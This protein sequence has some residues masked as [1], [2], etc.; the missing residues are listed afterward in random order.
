F[1]TLQYPPLWEVEYSEPITRFDNPT[2][3]FTVKPGLGSVVTV[4]VLNDQEGMDEDVGDLAF[5]LFAN[6][7][8]RNNPGVSV[9]ASDSD[10]YQIDGNT[11]FALL[12]SGSYGAFTND[13]TSSI[14]D[15]DM[16]SL[17]L[18]SYFG[19]SALR[20]QFV[21]PAA[22]F[23]SGIQDVDRMIDSIGVTGQGESQEEDSDNDDDN[24]NEN[25][26]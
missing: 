8:E 20:L 17:V 26:E 23:E 24:D 16:K 21:A 2:T 7:Y 4:S 3:T 5:S 9:D 18:L 25:E 6:Q 15:F 13:V 14:S 22:A 1:Y 11:A 12:T 19:D 10:T